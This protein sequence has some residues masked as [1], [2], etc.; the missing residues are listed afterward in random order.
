MLIKIPPEQWYRYHGNY[1]EVVDRTVIFRSL[2]EVLPPYYRHGVAIVDLNIF[3]K[4]EPGDVLQWAIRA[5][6]TTPPT[7]LSIG[8]QSG[9]GDENSLSIRGLSIPEDWGWVITEPVMV[10]EYK[11]YL[12]LFIPDLGK[13]IRVNTFA[14]GDPA[15]IE[16]LTAPSVVPWVIGGI[17]AAGGALALLSK[18]RGRER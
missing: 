1:P 18:A 4:Y 6:T 9:V 7:T 11:P 2:V 15:S 14:L 3:P 16:H 8:V 5:R 17:A 13:E 12:T 10:D